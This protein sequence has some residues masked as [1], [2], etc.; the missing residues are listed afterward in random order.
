[1]SSVEAQTVAKATVVTLE[2]IRND[3]SFEMFWQKV[4]SFAKKHEIDDPLL[5]RKRK[6]PKRF[7][8]GNAEPEHPSTPADDFRQKYFEALDL[9]IS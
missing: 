9:V 1:M 7:F 2:S 3:T 8:L 5:L 6:T 4:I